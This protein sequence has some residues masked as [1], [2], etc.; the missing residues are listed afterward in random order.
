MRLLWFWTVKLAMFPFFYLGFPIGEDS[1]KL[2]LWKTLIER[3]IIRLSE[4]KSHNLSLGGRLVHLKSVMS[5]FPVYFFS[6]F[7][8]AT[9]II[10]F[11][12]SFFLGGVGESEETR[13]IN[14]INWD[15]ICHKQ[16]DGGLKV[17]RI[18]EFNLSLI[19]KWCW[20]L[21]EEKK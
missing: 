18:K 15:T 14:W 1:R 4:W 2:N 10:T 13:K 19:G 8:A 6:F 7:K 12:E 3:F 16:E 5:S 9:G 21:R 20:R 11:L 17:G